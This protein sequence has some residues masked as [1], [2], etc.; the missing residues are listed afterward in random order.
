M[1]DKFNL[2]VAQIYMIFVTLISVFRVIVYVLNLEHVT[3][4]KILKREWEN[5]SVREVAYGMT[6]MIRHF[7]IFKCALSA[8][9]V[10]CLEGNP[11]NTRTLIFCSIFLLSDVALFLRVFSDFYEVHNVMRNANSKRISAKTLQNNHPFIPF[12]IQTFITSCGLIYFFS[13]LFNL[14]NVK[15][16]N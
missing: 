8:W 6:K 2:N 12:I 16:I 3:K 4:T 13:A 5:L 14:V 11:F 1:F 10:F 7:M 15:I 9:G